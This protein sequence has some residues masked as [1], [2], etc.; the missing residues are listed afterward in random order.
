MLHGCAWVCCCLPQSASAWHGIHGML[1]EDEIAVN[2]LTGGVS[3]YAAIVLPR[4]YHGRLRR[5]FTFSPHSDPAPLEL[6][7]EDAP[8][9]RAQAGGT[10]T[11]RA[12]APPAG[13]AGARER[14]AS[15][16][17]GCSAAR[18]S[19][20]A[21]GSGR[22]TQLE[23]DFA[24]WRGAFLWFLRKVT[25]RHRLHGSKAGGAGPSEPDGLPPAKP[26]LVKSPV[27]TARVRLLLKLFPRARFVFIHRHPLQVRA[28]SG[29]G[30]PGSLARVRG[31][32]CHGGSAEAAAVLT[33]CSGRQ[34]TSAYAHAHAHFA[35]SA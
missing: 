22:D 9:A 7:H 2:T 14:E 10:A 28:G 24:T 25:L 31:W 32:A 30:G 35:H 6:P 15:E 13:A 18:Q 34:P 29:T 16:G 21:S 17:V 26:L 1:Q 4:E 19:G 11:K 3:P 20:T 33:T 27:H 12:E 5:W 23:R 8:G